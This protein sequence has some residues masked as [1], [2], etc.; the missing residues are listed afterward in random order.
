MKV[1]LHNRVKIYNLTSGKN[2]PEWADEGKSKKQKKE[3][4]Q[5]AGD[6]SAAGLELIQD[7]DFPHFARCLFRSAD[8]SFFFAAGDYPPRLKCFSVEDMSQKFSFNADMPICGGVSLSPDFRKFALRSDNRQITVHNT[9]HVVDRLRVPHTQRCMTFHENSAELLS[10]GNSHE[11]F[12]I[13]L[14]SGAFVESYKSCSNEG[15]NAIDF[16][17]QHGL[18]LTGGENGVVEAWDPRANPN[19]PTGAIDVSSLDEIDHEETG[20][21]SFAVDDDGGY[22]FCA[23]TSTGQVAIFDIRLNK[24]LLVK[25]HMSELPIVK[26]LLHRDSNLKN[27]RVA[28][29]DSRAVKIWDRESGAN[30]TAVEAPNCDIYDIMFAKQEH[31]MAVA[32]YKSPDSGVLMMACD[33]PRVQVHFIPDLGRAPRWCTFLDSMA[34]SFDEEE[35]TTIFDDYKFIT[36]DEASKIGITST[37]IAAGKVRPA[38]HGFFVEAALY[39]DLKAVADPGA[40][41]REVEERKKARRRE[42]MDNRISSFKRTDTANAGNKYGRGA[43]NETIKLL[44]NEVPADVRPLL[45]SMTPETLELLQRDPRFAS[46]AG[47]GKFAFDPKNSQFVK[48]FREIGER[49][50]AAAERRDR[51]DRSHFKV[52]PMEDDDHGDN[53]RHHDDEQQNGNEKSATT[54]RHSDERRK[55]T[56]EDAWAREALRTAGSKKESGARRARSEDDQFNNNN[57]NKSRNVDDSRTVRSKSGGGQLQTGKERSSSS[58]SSSTFAIP[59][60]FKTTTKTLMMEASKDVAPTASDATMH[61]LRK[62]ERH[63][64]KLSLEERLKRN[65]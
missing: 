60:G 18:T 63:K 51:Y 17:P 65:G 55:V 22:I 8:G 6:S 43:A 25:D 50:Q 10:G 36:S 20:I 64:A 42:I 52:V 21:T 23:G 19:K 9:A 3:A 38:M 11:I 32:P 48:L 57:N 24:P 30:M 61:K 13:S 2:L 1:A 58:A 12:R 35:V 59:S 15:I 40:F 33:C 46:R 37:A 39:R 44:E 31:N 62:L 54:Y 7:L 28:S 27:T 49:R 47:Q 53:Q 26:I 5:A 45:K 56:E 16:F 34:E 14:D 41:T 4:M 29:A